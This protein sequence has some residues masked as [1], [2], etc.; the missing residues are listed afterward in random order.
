MTPWA[1]IVHV[2]SGTRP[3]LVERV[4][5]IFADR[6]LSLSA[7]LAT[8]RGDTSLLVLCFTSSEPLRDYLVRRLSRIDEVHKIE[9]RADDGRPPWAHLELSQH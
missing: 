7:L 3:G 1:L 9:V 5:R 8:T 2:Q 4:G 6:G